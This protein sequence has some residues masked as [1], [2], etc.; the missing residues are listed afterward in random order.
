MTVALDAFTA[1]GEPRPFSDQTLVDVRAGRATVIGDEQGVAV[2]RDGEL[3]LAVRREAR[4]RGLG[5]ALVTQALAL[6][7]GAAP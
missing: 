7:G 4:G 5:T 2:V 6:D 3:E 1:E